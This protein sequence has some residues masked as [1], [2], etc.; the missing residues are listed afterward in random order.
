[1]YTDG[2]VTDENLLFLDK[3]ILDIDNR[4]ENLDIEYY[5]YDI[6]IRKLLH[7]KY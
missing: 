4:L 3:E 7:T 5:L 1:M 2:D 6:L